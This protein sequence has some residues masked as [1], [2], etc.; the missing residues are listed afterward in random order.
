MYALLKSITYFTYLHIEVTIYH[1]TYEQALGRVK[2]YS[3]V[4]DFNG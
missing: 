4:R 2:S 3:V 1:L